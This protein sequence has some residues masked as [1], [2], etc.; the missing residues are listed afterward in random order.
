MDPTVCTYVFLDMLRTSLHDLGGGLHFFVSKMQ[1]FATERA[2]CNQAN[3]VLIVR[4][5]NVAGY[6]VSRRSLCLKTF[7]TA[8]A[9][10]Q[11][12]HERLRHQAP[13]L[14]CHTYFCF[15]TKNHDVDALSDT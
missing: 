10:F 4:L 15:M 12:K 11:S 6:L 9:T 13:Y 7:Q 1:N 3:V 2:N 5:T 14:Q 8:G